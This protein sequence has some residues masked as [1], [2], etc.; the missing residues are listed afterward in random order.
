MKIPLQHRN[1]KISWFWLSAAIKSYILYKGTLLYE[2]VI[3]YIFFVDEEQEGERALHQCGDCKLI[4][5][6]FKRYITHKVQKECWAAENEESNN[7]KTDETEWRPDQNDSF[8]S[9]ETSPTGREVSDLEEM[10]EEVRL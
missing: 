5:N 1:S 4:F 6:N 7:R 9:Q 10:E 2:E 8:S 3:S